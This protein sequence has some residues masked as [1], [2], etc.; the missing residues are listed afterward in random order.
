[1]E[2]SAQASAPSPAPKRATAG[3]VVSLVAGILILLDGIFLAVSGDFLSSLGYGSF[4]GAVTVL[5]SITVLFA[6]IV[7][8]GAWLIHTLGREVAGGIIV[9]IF[10]LISIVTGDGFVIGL[11][12]GIIGGAIGLAKK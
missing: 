5:G 3:F 9:L 2:S 11:I 8:V 1:M 6:I 7:F 12:L 4:A 10:S